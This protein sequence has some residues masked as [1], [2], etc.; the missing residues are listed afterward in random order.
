MK[1]QNFVSMGLLGTAFALY[2][3]VGPSVCDAAG[4]IR[5]HPD[6]PRYFTDDTGRAI[7][8]T[9]LHAHA[10]FQERGLEGITPDFDYPEYLDYLE[11][12]NHN[13]IRLW[14]WE[15]ATWMQF[16]PPSVKVRYKPLPYPRTGPGTA[17]DGGLKFD[18]NQWNQSYFD[19]LRDRVIQ[20]GNRGMYVSVMFWQ[21]FSIEQKQSGCVELPPD[22]SKG[23][24]WQ[25]H[26]YNINNN[27]N[28]VDGDADNDNNGREL[29]TLDLPTIT[30]LQK[31]YARKVI[32][33]L[34][35]Q[36]HIIWEIS[37][38]SHAQSIAWQQHMIDYIRS[39]E[40]GKPKQHLVGMTGYC[41]NN[42]NLFNSTADWISPN[43]DGGYRDN[44]PAA[45]GSH[46]IISDTDHLW[47]LGGNRDWVWKS[48]LR[49]MHPIF[50]DSYKDYRWGSPAVPDPTYDPIRIAL[51]H[52]RTYAEKMNLAYMTPQNSL[53]STTYC[54]AN[55]G[56]EYLVYQPVSGADFSV[57]LVTG[58]Y[59]Y[60]WFDPVS[61]L[62]TATGSISVP[63]GNH[64]FTN[65]YSATAVLYLLNTGPRMPVFCDLGGPDIN[66][67]LRHNQCDDGDTT[68]TNI[69]DRECRTNVDTVQ[70]RYFYFGID[71]P[72][73]GSMHEAY[74]SVEY[75][76]TGSGTLRLQYD[77]D[78][79]DDVVA[80]YKTAGT[81]DLT[82]DNA[83]K[84][85]TFHVT[86]A[87]FGD[88][89]NCSSDFRVG[90][91]NG[92]AFYVD[93]IFL[94]DML[95]PTIS[96]HPVSL[97]LHKGQTAQ[98]QIVATGEGTL[99]YQWQKD[100]ADLVDGGNISGVNMDTL[101]IGNVQSTD[102]GDYCCVVTNNGG[103]TASNSASLTL[104][105][106]CDFDIDDDVDQEDFGHFQ[107]CLTGNSNVQTD[108][109]C[110]DCRLDEDDDVD[111]SDFVIFQG[112][113]SGANIPPA[114]NCAE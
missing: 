83:W 94:S 7:Y 51:G 88:R 2:A 109:V 14:T 25:G 24:P 11:S 31:A 82:G 77:S 98:F 43:K 45:T 58:T 75:Y 71:Y 81:V 37:N 26:P 108:P 102:L 41:F 76:D 35:D 101:A 23:N 47:G 36:D 85:Y 29:H 52:T 50:M 100:G 60:E 38:E 4:L 40:A 34:N 28:G 18:L 56:I 69:G 3:L 107:K 99:E 19:R 90:K 48:F 113:M 9:G 80:K 39:Y 74:I 63:D 70:D 66:N 53:S 33:T 17:L 42:S 106:F 21:G 78:T 59:S 49:G 67:G 105:Y 57:N 46:I 86:D 30:N 111:L 87:Y 12:L 27:I 72:Y 6:N 64:S 62:I 89:Q 65:P 114:P 91:D 95:P 55:P 10:N 32:D 68:A 79:G 84:R 103:S 97:K 15:H 22:P 112:C 13:F 5:V 1:K 73:E 110:M 44:P 16:D 93:V 104:G 8:F 20:A 61:G 92:G 54:L 96:Q